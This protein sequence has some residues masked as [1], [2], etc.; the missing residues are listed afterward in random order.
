MNIFQLLD[1]KY[2]GE[3]WIFLQEVRNRPGFRSSNSLDGVAMGL[4]ESRGCEVIGFEVKISRGDWLRELKN[5]KKA[6]VGYS[7]VD[8][9]YLACDKGVA[10]ETE[11]PATWGWL[12]K[13][14]NRLIE[15]KKAPYKTAPQ[16][17]LD[18]HFVSMMLRRAKKGMPDEP[19]KVQ[20][21]AREIANDSI[22]YERE[23]WKKCEEGL[24]EK[25]KGL[26]KELAAIHRE[27]GSR[28]IKDISRVFKS[29][30]ALYHS[31]AK[32]RWGSD[33]SE[34]LIH[35]AVRLENLAKTVRDSSDEVKKMIEK[36]HAPVKEPACPPSPSS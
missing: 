5:P 13:Q 4:W 9:F 20:D 15:K 33:A 35:A 36:A 24:C 25:V 7:L 22:K 28:D 8:R 18:R 32:S 3:E 30:D 2:G 16:E 10:F 26:E 11:I 19:S 6:E 23:T 31:T 34:D 14:G 27:L 29:L 1:R 21:L 17:R 12:E